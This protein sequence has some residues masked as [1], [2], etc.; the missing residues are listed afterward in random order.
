MKSLRSL[1]FKLCYRVAF[2]A[3]DFIHDVDIKV[4]QSCRQQ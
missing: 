4:S 3:L 2:V 1:F